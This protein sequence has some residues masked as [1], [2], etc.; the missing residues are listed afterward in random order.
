MIVAAHQPAFLPWLGYLDKVAR[1]DVFVV[2]D[3]LQFEVGNFQHRNRVRLASGPHWLTVPLLRGRQLDRISDKRIDNTGLGGRHH[4]QHRAWRTLELNYHRAPHWGALAAEL[5]P[6]FQ[7][8]WDR[9]IDVDLCMF[10]IACRWFHIDTPIVRSSTLGLRGA[11]TER[12]AN[13]CD[14]I[15]A[16]TYL[17]GKG[18]S[19]SYLDL[20]L[21]GDRGIHVAWQQFAHPRYRQQ[22]PGFVS[23]LGFVDFAANAG[24]R[25]EKV[26]IA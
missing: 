9:L 6:V 2:M 16:R 19:T 17:S 25:L 24:R 23:H 10:D 26:V 1:A 11:R 7:R 8:R 22:H 3:D 5:A 14:A 18:G 15:G 13:M 12:I 21:L 20:K 4:W